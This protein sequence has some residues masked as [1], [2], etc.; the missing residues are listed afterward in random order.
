MHANH[1]PAG[2]KKAEFGCDRPLSHLTDDAREGLR[3][4]RSHFGDLLVPVFVP[5]WNRIAPELVEHLPRIGYRGLST[6]GKRRQPEAAGGIVQVNT[7]LD[8]IAWHEGR[9]LRK[10]HALL[11]ELARAVM[12]QTERDGVPEP[13][14]LL[15]HHLVHDDAIWLFCEELLRR[16][17]KYSIVRFV[18]P[19]AMFV[20]TQTI[21]T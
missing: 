7:H 8:P 12:A 20:G 19:R 15:T 5:P 6:F 14:G 2:D 4:A 16:L 1:A 3:L 9:S 13:I 18:D 11:A 10:P 21:A 17:A